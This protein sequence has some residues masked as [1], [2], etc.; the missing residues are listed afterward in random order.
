[1]GARSRNR[2]HCKL[3]KA[4]RPIRGRRFI[5]RSRAI[6]CENPEGKP[7][8]EISRRGCCWRTFHNAIT[9][10]RRGGREKAGANRQKG[11]DQRRKSIQQRMKPTPLFDGPGRAISD[12][13]TVPRRCFP[14]FPSRNPSSTPKLPNAAKI[15]IIGKNGRRI[16]QIHPSFVMSSENNDD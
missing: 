9:A 11:P 6:K 1:M 10:R 13:P 4:T 15:S 16:P 12:A 7:Q 2:K 14:V 8:S 3:G 5:E